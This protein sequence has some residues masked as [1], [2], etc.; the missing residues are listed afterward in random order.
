MS[1]PHGRPKGR[2]TQSGAA[3]RRTFVTPSLGEGAGGWAL[4]FP[5]GFAPRT[6]SLGEGA[7]GRVLQ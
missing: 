5:T 1:A 3:T 6:P 7:G 2:I 4:Q